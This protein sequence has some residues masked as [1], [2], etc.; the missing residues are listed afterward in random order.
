MNETRT[1]STILGNTVTL[2]SDDH[3]FDV[4][5]NGFVV[6]TTGDETEAEM[7]AESLD[8]ALAILGSQGLLKE[9]F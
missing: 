8:V 4:S 3:D 2:S 9:N 1:Y 7:V 5:L 6:L